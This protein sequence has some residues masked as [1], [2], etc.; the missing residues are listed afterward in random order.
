MTSR[1][2]PPVHPTMNIAIVNCKMGETCTPSNSEIFGNEFGLC[3]PLIEPPSNVVTLGKEL[4]VF[5]EEP[6]G[7]A[8]VESLMQLF[9]PIE[10]KPLKEEP[11]APNLKIEL[12]F[13]SGMTSRS[14]PPVHP[15]MNIAIINCKMGETCT[16]SNTA[17]FG[18]E[19]GL[20]TPKTMTP[21]LPPSDAYIRG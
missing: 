19:F 21:T 2:R 13:V 5:Q 17:I 18:N 8:E 4:D 10:I 12:C 6:E 11:I 14:R 7:N 16:P 9:P 1:S 20:C 3:T 15:T